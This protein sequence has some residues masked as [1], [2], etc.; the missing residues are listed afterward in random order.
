MGYNFTRINEKIQAYISVEFLSYVESENKPVLLNYFIQNFSRS[1]MILKLNLSN[2][3]FVSTAFPQD[4]L[5]ITF[6]KPGL[7]KAVLDGLQ[8]Q[9]NY[10]LEKITIPTQMASEEEYQQML[11]L[12][13]DSMTT[14]LVTF[15]IPFAFMMLMKFSLNKIWSLYNMLQ[16]LVNVKNYVPLVVPGNLSMVLDLIENTVYF[17]PLDD[18]MV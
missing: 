14:M 2:P 13:S 5:K 11:S 7:F 9:R 12:V 18:P 4:R 16:L 1:E 8:L 15:A 10:I 17:S 6:L 3:I